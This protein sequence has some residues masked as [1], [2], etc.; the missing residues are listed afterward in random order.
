MNNMQIAG[1]GILLKK[2]IPDSRSRMLFSFN[3]LIR[4]RHEID[5]ASL[6]DASSHFGELDQSTATE[7]Y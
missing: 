1:K 2:L 6:A 5:F 7:C 4:S 3:K